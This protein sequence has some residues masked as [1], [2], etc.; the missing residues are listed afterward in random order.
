MNIKAERIAKISKGR[1]IRIVLERCDAQREST[2]TVS[3]LRAV[4]I[5]LERCDNLIKQY[6]LQRKGQVANINKRY[7]CEVSIVLQ[8]CDTQ[9]CGS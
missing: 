3:K 7:H 5:A 8:R 9:R 6:A 1:S 4:K 2:K